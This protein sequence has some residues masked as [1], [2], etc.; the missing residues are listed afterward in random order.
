[1]EGRQV[2]LLMDNFSTHEAAVASIRQS[3]D[4][5]KNTLVVW[6]PANST[7]KYQPLNQGIIRTWKAYWKR[8][9][10]AYLLHKY[11]SKHD[12]MATMNILKA[13]RWGIRAWE[14]DV[15]D[16]TIQNCFQKAL[17]L[18]ALET[19]PSEANITE[20]ELLADI[21]V[22]LARVQIANPSIREIIDINQFLNPLDEKVDNDPNL[23]ALDEQVLARFAGQ[24]EVKAES[25]EEPEIY[26]KVSHLEAQQLLYRLRLYEEQQ[27]PG[28]N[29]LIQALNRHEKTILRRKFYG[30]R[31][32]Q[33][34]RSYF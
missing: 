16:L 22:K 9:W 12:P 19:N 23:E 30:E 14:D 24:P 10:V 28:D 7:S 26:P 3:D 2:V 4:P 5:L 34:I 27:T 11:D 31:Q 15:K 20:T 32:Q 25:D 29:M 1:M 8:C 33:D 18:R 21:Q 17:D 13:L 6:L